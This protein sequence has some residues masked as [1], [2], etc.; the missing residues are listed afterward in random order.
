MYKTLQERYQEVTNSRRLK[1]RRRR[2]RIKEKKQELK[3]KTFQQINDIAAQELN[4]NSLHASSTG[5]I[6]NPTNENSSCKD[7]Q[8]CVTSKK[9]SYDDVIDQEVDEFLNTGDS[10]A[11]SSG[12]EKGAS[13]KKSIGSR[14]RHKRFLLK[15]HSLE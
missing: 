13:I 10:T 1:R 2:Q 4:I 12:E 8:E 5:K 14:Q 15:F 9:D 11:V 6:P 3:A 7:V